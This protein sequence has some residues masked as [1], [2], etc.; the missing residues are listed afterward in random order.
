MLF[1]NRPGSRTRSHFPNRGGPPLGMNRVRYFA[2]K[3]RENSGGG[4]GKTRKVNAVAIKTTVG[5][6]IVPQSSKVYVSLGG[7]DYVEMYAKDLRP[8]TKILFHKQGVKVTMAEVEPVLMK[9]NR[10][11]ASFEHLFQSDDAGKIIIMPNERPLPKLRVMLIGGLAK[12]GVIE[13]PLL[14]DRILFNKSDFSATQYQQMVEHVS[15]TLSGSSQKIKRS[16]SAIRAWLTG[17]TISPSDFSIYVPISRINPDFEKFSDPEG[18]FAKNYE[19]Y[20]KVRRGI[21]AYLS[22]LSE[23]GE[24]GKKSSSE[25]KPPELSLAP[26]INIVVG[27]FIK[28]V[29]DQFVVARVCEVK[30]V[31]VGKGERREKPDEGLA[32]GVVTKKPED[33]VAMN[34]RPVSEVYQHLRIMEEI[35]FNIVLR[36]LKEKSTKYTP[37]QIAQFTLT[38][39]RYR[40]NPTKF[41]ALDTKRIS[42]VDRETFE[43]SQR[44]AERISQMM[45]SGEINDVPDT[46]GL[47]L[48]ALEYYFECHA[49]MPKLYLDVLEMYGLQMPMASPTKEMTRKLVKSMSKL[50]GQY[51]IDVQKTPK[52]STTSARSHLKKDY[53]RFVTEP[54]YAARYRKQI[55]TQQGIRFFTGTEV[56]TELTKMGIP[57]LFSLIPSTAFSDSINLGIS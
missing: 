33:E 52:M 4:G 12:L 29:T 41:D 46:H 43:I 17:D 22:F 42:D 14:N 39:M 20:V 24:G 53:V 51:G 10:Y 5:N 7:T 8:D 6:S 35:A 23:Q 40:R 34:M 2:K 18:D 55:E 56:R 45:I 13:D 54:E 57:Q 11:T 19:L 3:H 36:A 9:S 47:A 50:A 28:Q 49:I 38:L 30:D 44:N 37:F 31:E 27:H 32:K 21:M 15:V 48:K 16:D 1:Y 26:E 25:Y